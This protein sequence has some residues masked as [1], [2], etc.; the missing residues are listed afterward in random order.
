MDVIGLMLFLAGAALLVMNIIQAVRW[1]TR[2]GK[3]DRPFTPKTSVVHQSF[4]LTN[5]VVFLLSFSKCGLSY[6]WLL[7]GAAAAFSSLVGLI[8]IPFVYRTSIVKAYNEP[9]K[10]MKGYFIGRSGFKLVAS[11]FLLCLWVYS[12]KHLIGQQ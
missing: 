9:S 3:I 1:I 5:G 2:R 10:G 8:S 7:L 6:L 12:W 11:V 4:V